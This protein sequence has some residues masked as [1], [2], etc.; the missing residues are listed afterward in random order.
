MWNKSPHPGR[1]A[2]AASP[3]AEEAKDGAHA[4]SAGATP[5][6]AATELASARLELLAPATALPSPPSAAGRTPAGQSRLGGAEAEEELPA[7]V[8]RPPQF[9]A[10]GGESSAAPSSSARAARRKSVSWSA[11]AMEAEPAVRSARRPPRAALNDGATPDKTTPRRSQRLS[12]RLS[13][14]RSRAADDLE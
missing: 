4:P 2:L 6:P 8:V 13:G 14:S 10:L 7:T 12:E 5:A 9:P 3:E 1:A 11:A